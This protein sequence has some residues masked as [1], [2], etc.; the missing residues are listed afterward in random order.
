M[1]LHRHLILPAL[2]L[3]LASGSAM[4]AEKK[5][6]PA[7]AS[8]L[9]PEALEARITDL[10]RQ[11]TLEE[12]ASLCSGKDIW[13]TRPIE[14]LGVP[15]IWVSDGPHGLRRAPS[16][17]TAGYGDQAPATCFPTASCL[18]A[19]WD[20]DLIGQVGKALGEECQALGVN[21]LLGP[22]V[23]IKRH[24]LG[25][26]NFEYLSEDPV[27]AGE[28]GA[29]LINGVQSQGVGTSLKHYALNSE[30]TE[31]MRMNSVVDERTMRELYLAPFETVVKKAQP[32]T[33]MAS[34]NRINGVYGTEN[35][36]TLTDML[37][38]EFGFQG[39]VISDWNAVVNR[40]KGLQAGMN[41]EMPGS[42]SVNDRLIV[43]AVKNG[44]LDE[45]VL[46]ENARLILRTVLKAK[47]LQKAGV[48]QNLD[49]HHKLGRKVAAE[50]STLLKNEGALLPI[51][52][53]YKTIAILGEFLRNPRIQGNG[54]SEVKP[55]K[56][57]SLEKELQALAGKDVKLV[58]AQGYSL[59][60]DND[61]SL[62]EEA[63]AVAAKA[64]LAI[65]FAG[66]PLSYESEGID[67]RHINLP[68]AH[69]K[70]IEAI[71]GVQKKT[72]VVLTN[73]SAVAMPWSGN[74]GAILETW[75]GGEAGAGG[76]ADVLF[77][78]VNP[79]G[80][81]AETFPK[82][83]EDTPAFFNFPGEE[84]EVLYGE[85]MFVGYRYY[86]AKG[87]EPLFPFGH[88]LSYTTFGYSD[89]QAPKVFTDKDT[90]KVSLR[91]KNTGSVAGKE[92]VQLYVA[93]KQ[94]SLVRP[95]KE[96]KKF[97]KV[98]LQPG[99][100]KDVSFELSLRDFSFFNPRLHRWVAESGE[101]ELL[102]GSSSRD[103]R[104]KASVKLDSSEF[105]AARF[106]ELTYIREF[107]ANPRTR[108]LALETFKP[109]IM[110]FAAPGQTVEQVSIQDFFLDHPLAKMPH[111]SE[112]RVSKEAVVAFLKQAQALD[113]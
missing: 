42:N 81:L 32:W 64:D 94:A 75:L 86:D 73:G 2:T 28:M 46:D 43:E 90:V 101:F 98:E 93:D 3:L 88:G 41:I 54:S 91:V 92:V 49:A 4:A 96:L 17:D 67:R 108:A 48:S 27:V 12:K 21:V 87:I 45:K 100:T 77:G 84:R 50:A 74:V 15:S 18:A 39:I 33:V 66:L 9:Q 58:Y 97:A 79:S 109:W 63:K 111:L 61:L 35:P 38:K 69:D 23:N 24:P 107:L 51:Q 16:T 80:K 83:L 62:I 10:I 29:A 110:T 47:A 30:E 55:P 5:D 36:Y 26:R 8:L 85:R 78:K 71:A 89:L 56:V 14:R 40:V 53:Q 105:I 65:V 25:G 34:Y 13:G 102:V 31:R 99:E 60:N 112:G 104:A 113:K 7:Q 59:K 106:D 44:S 68:P 6:K 103:I 20:V 76:V 19:T 72:A 11:M 70:L 82:R 95:A 52:G 37:R 1:R 22:G 57:D